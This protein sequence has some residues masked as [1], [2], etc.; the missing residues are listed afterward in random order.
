MLPNKR[1]IRKSEAGNAFLFILLGVVLFAALGITVS[2]SMRSDSTT[3]LTKREASL[4]AS[5]IIAY[6]QRIARGVDRARRNGCSENDISFN[7][8]FESGYNHTPAAPVKCVIFDPQGVGLSWASPPD[9]YFDT[10]QYLAAGQREW[11]FH[12]ETAWEGK[13]SAASELSAYLPNLQRDVCLEINRGLGIDNPLDE[14]P[15]INQ[16]FDAF[17]KYQGSFG[18]SGGTIEAADINIPPG[19]VETAICIRADSLN[20]GA[21]PQAYVYIHF[22]LER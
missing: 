22:L 16:N 17:S 12:G 3:T 5:D 8:P 6:G 18:T 1:H 21:N 4:A 14:P 9:R 2:R 15:V 19:D 13:V 7:N 20:G 10:A 11:H